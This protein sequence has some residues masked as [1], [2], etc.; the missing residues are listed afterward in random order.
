MASHAM[1]GMFEGVEGD[2]KQVA[3][4]S[5]PFHVNKQKKKK[6]VSN[7]HSSQFLVVTHDY[8]VWGHDQLFV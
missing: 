8:E 7:Q 4:S 2:S 1:F 5:R 3:D 6:R